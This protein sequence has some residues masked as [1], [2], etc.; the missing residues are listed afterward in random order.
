VLLRI[1]FEF[2]PPL[3]VAIVLVRYAPPSEKGP[4][5]FSVAFFSASWFWGQLL[6]IW[7]QEDQRAR[8]RIY[9][10]QLWE[11]SDQASGAGKAFVARSEK[12]RPETCILR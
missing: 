10:A 3:I 1:V 12:E 9:Q 5:A 8:R 7:Y 4:V 6:R 11:I 2:G